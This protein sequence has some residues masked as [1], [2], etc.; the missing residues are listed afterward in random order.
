MK[1]ILKNLC[2]VLSLSGGGSLGI[3][4]I[5]I[6][7]KIYNN[8]EFDLITGISAGALNAMF[9]SHYKNNFTEG[10]EKVKNIWLNMGNDNVYSYS[11]M[12]PYRLWSV[13]STDPLLH[14]I[15]HVFQNLPQETKIPTIIG[16]TNLN[17]NRLDLFDIH[18]YSNEDQKNI[19]LASSA[20]PLAFPPII[21]NGSYY[22]DGGFIT[23]EI[24]YN[25][26]EYINCDLFNITF[27]DTSNPVDSHKEIENVRDYLGGILS[28]LLK[29]FDVKLMTLR[30]CEEPKGEI[31]V[32]YIN[33]PHEITMLN[34]DKPSKLYE[35]GKNFNYTKYK[36]C[37]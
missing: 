33:K 26:N 19:L 8:Q 27:I 29:N 6:L 18:K 35:Y 23:N 9:L 13:Y 30:K 1:V 12:N 2:N 3:T 16:S 7:E 37:L 31:H 28:G 17:L 14:T 34:F 21:I 10:I 22:V 11:L 32:Y 20:V 25:I 15:E 5:S 4:E 24:I 36:Y